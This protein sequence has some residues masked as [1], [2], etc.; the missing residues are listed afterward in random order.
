MTIKKGEW[1]L[2]LE[3]EKKTKNE[4]HLL[5]QCWEQQ[6]TSLIAFIFSVLVNVGKKIDAGLKVDASLK[7]DIDCDYDIILRKHLLV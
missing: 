1:L 4:I 7:V 6:T 3:K 2:L 5:G